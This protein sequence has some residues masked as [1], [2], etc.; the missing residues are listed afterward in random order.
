MCQPIYNTTET[1]C[2]ED[3]KQQHS[4]LCFSNFQTLIYNK[5]EL[6]WT[7]KLL[8]NLCFDIFYSIP[9]DRAS[10]VLEDLLLQLKLCFY[11]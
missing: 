10:G 7:E 3:T 11:S 2:P 4:W 8:W 1:D 9:I 5:P 6:K